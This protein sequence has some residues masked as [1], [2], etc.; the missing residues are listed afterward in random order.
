[1][2]SARIVRPILRY[3]PVFNFVV[4]S[5]ALAFQITVLYPWHNELD[6]EFH[7]LKRSHEKKLK[8]FHILKV[9]QMSEMEGKINRIL[10]SMKQDEV[11]QMRTMHNFA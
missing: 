2:A 1:M 5:S 7:V 3:L 9:Q 8:E 6:R 10:D 4:A 11:K